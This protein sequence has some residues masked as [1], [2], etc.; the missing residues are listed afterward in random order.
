MSGRHADRDEGSEGY[1]GSVSRSTISHSPDSPAPSR[2]RRKRAAPRARPLSMPSCLDDWASQPQSSQTGALPPIHSPHSRAS[3]FVQSINA[4][5]G[6]SR[7]RKSGCFP[8]AHCRMRGASGRRG[9]GGCAFAFS[10]ASDRNFIMA[11][12]RKRHYKARYNDAPHATWSGTM[13]GA[14]RRKRH[15]HAALMDE[16]ADGLIGKDFPRVQVIDQRLHRWR[17]CQGLL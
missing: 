17:L 16:D 15:G 5:R 1:L 12:G 9:A 11:S 14:M 13:I 7:D 2:R 10:S 4:R 3:G 6:E 8:F